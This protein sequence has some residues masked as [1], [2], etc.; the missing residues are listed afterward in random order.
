MVEGGEGGN[1]GG[2][3]ERWGREW[4]RGEGGNGGGV[5]CLGGESVPT[6]QGDS[7]TLTV[8]YTRV[9]DWRFASC[10]QQTY[11]VFVASWAKLRLLQ[12]L[13][14]QLVSEHAYEK[15]KSKLRVGNSCDVQ[16][17]LFIVVRLSDTWEVLFLLTQKE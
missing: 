7:L 5:E 4:K 11:S 6:T 1:G 10:Q 16:I 9:A 3:R 2:V 13:F 8:G 15:T 12:I 14:C 17:L